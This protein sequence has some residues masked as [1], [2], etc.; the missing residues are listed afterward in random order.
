MNFWSCTNFCKTW[1]QELNAASETW[2]EVGDYC[3]PESYLQRMPFDSP[4]WVQAAISVPIVPLGQRALSYWDFS[5]NFFLST[6]LIIRA[7]IM[8][9]G[10]FWYKTSKAEEGERCIF[11]LTQLKCPL[12]SSNLILTGFILGVGGTWNPVHRTW[13]AGTAGG[14][15]NLG[16][17]KL[18]FRKTAIT[19]TAQY[20]E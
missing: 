4:S 15:N 19:Q 17:L 13:L 20:H 2:G 16:E 6:F 18:T 10:Q 7:N 1:R 9:N 11:Q 8:W 14:E 5:L 3:V 12:K